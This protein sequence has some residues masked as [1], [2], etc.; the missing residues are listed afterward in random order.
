MH[1]RKI[2][3]ILYYR[4]TVVDKNKSQGSYS[5]TS[6]TSSIQAIILLVSINKISLTVDDF[7]LNDNKWLNCKVYTRHDQLLPL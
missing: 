3:C 5:N 2:I 4:H 1:S 7:R 6:T